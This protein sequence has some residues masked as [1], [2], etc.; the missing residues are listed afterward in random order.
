MVEDDKKYAFCV[1][2]QRVNTVHL[3]IEAADEYEA[4]DIAVSMSEEIPDSDWDEVLHTET[5][6]L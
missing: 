3:N 1:L 5:I 2:V 4:M 6:D